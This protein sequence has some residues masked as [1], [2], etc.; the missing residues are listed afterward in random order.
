MRERVL[1]IKKRIYTELFVDRMAALYI[2][3]TCIRGRTNEGNQPVALT[4]W[5]VKYTLQRTA[6][7]ISKDVGMRDDVKLS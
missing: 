5:R 1:P 6:I 7:L 3:E 4:D 2:R